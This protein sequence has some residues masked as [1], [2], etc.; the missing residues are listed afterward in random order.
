MTPMISTLPSAA[1]GRFSAVRAAD[2]PKKPAAEGTAVGDW[3]GLFILVLTIIGT[4][5]VL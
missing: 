5:S 1:F 2:R 4:F 3:A